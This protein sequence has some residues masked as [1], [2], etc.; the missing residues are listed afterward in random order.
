L[1]VLTWLFGRVASAQARLATDI[2]ARPDP[3]IGWLRNCDA[4]DVAL[5]QLTF[6]R[7]GV[8][9]VSLSSVARHGRGMWLEI[10]GSDGQVVLGSG[11]Q[12]DYIHGFTMQMARRG[13]SLEPQAEE[14]AYGFART[15]PDGRV[16]PVARLLDWWATAVGEGRPMVPGLAEGLASQMVADAVRKASETGMAVEMT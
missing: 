1:Y 14:S 16:A 15:W 7:G 4:E 2:T 5:I 10:Y 3:A 9:Q 6:A 11:N 8:A 12:K 13:G